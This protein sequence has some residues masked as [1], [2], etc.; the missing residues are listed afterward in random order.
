MLTPQ[1]YVKLKA[2][3]SPC[4]YGRTTK[5]GTTQCEN[6]RFN[7]TQGVLT[8]SRTIISAICEGDPASVSRYIKWIQSIAS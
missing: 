6:C 1:E 2:K 8:Y 3:G 5:V 4:P 7:K